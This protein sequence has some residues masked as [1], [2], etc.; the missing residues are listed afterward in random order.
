MR[1]LV[2]LLVLMFVAGCNLLEHPLYVLFGQTS[3]KVK[4]EYAG[5]RGKKTVI[6]VATGPGVD[7]EYPGARMNLALATADVL[8][9]HV[10]DAEFVDAR[11]VD[12]F[13]REDLDWLSLPMAELGEK[14]S[15]DLVLY[16]DM[17]EF[18]LAEPESINLL[19]AYVTADIRVYEMDSAN[20]NKPNYQTEISITYPE[21]GPLPMSDVA[22]Q[23]VMYRSIGLFAEE[24]SYVFYDHRVTV[25]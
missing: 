3:K 2:L 13:Q 11:M 9:Q 19:R 5:L 14:F 24:L 1:K 8:S 6:F 25:E 20:P 7:F 21:Q 17:I 23:R 18:T 4:A 12:T 22:M 10:K 15:A 16:L